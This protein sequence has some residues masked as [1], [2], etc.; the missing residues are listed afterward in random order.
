V[1]NPDR[2]EPDATPEAQETTAMPDADAESRE[3]QWQDALRQRELRKLAEFAE[4]H[5][6][7]EVAAQIR[8]QAQVRRPLS[9][10][11]PKPD[12]PDP[13][14]VAAILARSAQRWEAFFACNRRKHPG[15]SDQTCPEKPPSPA[16][17]ADAQARAEFGPGADDPVDD[18]AP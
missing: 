9:G 18:A 6:H 1:K 14:T 5:G 2:P 12:S 11:P 13:D 3:R 16:R 15:H 7:P 10:P 4:R 17:A 8:E